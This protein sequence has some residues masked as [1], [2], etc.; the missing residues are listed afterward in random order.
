[1][2][3]NKSYCYTF[4]SYL[5]VGNVFNAQFELIKW[6]KMFRHFIIL[7]KGEKMAKGQNVKKNVK[8]ESAKSMKEKKA[9]KK[10]KKEEKKNSGILK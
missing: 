1:M 6:D 7:I 9:D 8:K 4:F 2:F 5:V 3:D 10:A